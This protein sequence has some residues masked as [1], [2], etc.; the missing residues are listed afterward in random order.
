MFGLVDDFEFSMQCGST[1][2]DCDSGVKL[3]N[4]W[5]VGK[6]FQSQMELHSLALQVQEVLKHNPHA[7]TCTCR[8]AQRLID[9]DPVGMTGSAC[10]F[11]RST[12]SMSRFLGHQPRTASFQSRPRDSLYMLDGIDQECTAHVATNRRRMGVDD[13]QL[14]HSGGESSHN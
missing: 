7:A 6:K 3:V 5:K 4:T 2:V 9:K 12:W 14:S 13:L 1:S 10:H 11:T 8:R